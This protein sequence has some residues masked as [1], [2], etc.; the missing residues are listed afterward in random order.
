M[1]SLKAKQALK[2]GDIIYLDCSPQA[3]HEQKGRRPAIVVSCDDYNASLSP[4][5]F[6]API[7][8]QAKGYPFEV[9]L[10]DNLKISGVVLADQ[11]RS[12]DFIARDGSFVC[13][14]PPDIIDDVQQLLAAILGL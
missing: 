11:V 3:G 4:F 1:A 13:A 10:P 7:T 14:T 12:F 8:N 5:I 6:V 2:A 9:P